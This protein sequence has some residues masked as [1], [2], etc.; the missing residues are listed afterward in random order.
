[1][2]YTILKNM[3]IKLYCQIENIIYCNEAIIFT[4]FDVFNTFKIYI[5][6]IKFFIVYLFMYFASLPH[7]E[8][9]HSKCVIL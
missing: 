1:M 9:N 8:Q 3:K 4:L 6:C 5:L 2:E 7:Y